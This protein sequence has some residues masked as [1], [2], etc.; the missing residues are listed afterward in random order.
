MDLSSEE[1]DGLLTAWAL[2]ALDP[3]TAA[4]VERMVVDQP[5]LAERAAELT[6]VAAL[7]GESMARTP[8]PDLRAGLL[9]AAAASGP[10]LVEPADPVAVFT[11]Q[12]ESLALLLPTI[13]DADWTLRAAPYRWTLHGLVA[14]L[15]VIE[16]YTAAQL[17]LAPAV[18][19]GDANHLE[20]GR[21]IIEAQVV[22]PAAATITAWTDRARATVAALRSDPAVDLDRAVA[23]HRYPFTVASVLIARA[24]ETWTHA[25]DIRRAVRRAVEAPSAGDLRTMSQLSV[26]SLPSILPLVDPAIDFGGARVVLTGDGGGTFD[27]GDPQRRDAVVV[28][29]VVDYCRHAARRLSIDDLAPTIEGDEVTA[30]RLLAASRVFAV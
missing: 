26:T 21:S 15:L 9:A 29:D 4:Q 24:F 5:G 18:P 20:M 23:F 10:E 19:D 8:P 3:A 22:G 30:R 2:D 6:E 16:R 17:G 11:S 28:A 27:L 12:I 25:D 14:H 1:M 13:D 7:L